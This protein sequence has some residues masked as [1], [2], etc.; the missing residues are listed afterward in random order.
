VAW[1]RLSHRLGGNLDG[2]HILR[3]YARLALAS[4]PGALAGGAVGLG[5]T[6][7][8]GNGAFASLAALVVGGGVLLAVFV[9]AAKRLR[10]VELNSM[11][12]MARG[13][14]GR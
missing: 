12:A 14:L 9:V 2:T 7:M 8:L 3:T 4:V 11:I 13:R 1:R 6:R 5:I 10:I